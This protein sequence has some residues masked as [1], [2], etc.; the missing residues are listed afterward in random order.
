[1]FSLELFRAVDALIIKERTLMQNTL[2][3]FGFSLTFPL[4]FLVGI[5][6]FLCYQR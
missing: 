2:F 1:M 4:W 5:E 6:G 3:K